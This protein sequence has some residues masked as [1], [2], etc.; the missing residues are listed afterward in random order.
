MGE[1]EKGGAIGEKLRSGAVK[2]R[3]TERRRKERK[4]IEGEK[5]GVKGVKTD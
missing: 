5:S 3:S 4:K 1:R 2:R